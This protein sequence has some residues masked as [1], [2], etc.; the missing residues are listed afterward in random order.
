MVSRSGANTITEILTLG[1]L[2]ILIPIPWT[3][4]NEQGKNA[5]MVRET[6]LAIVLEEKVL[7][8]ATLL[9]AIDEQIEVLYKDTHQMVSI[10]LMYKRR[11]LML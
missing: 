9:Q 4:H 3:S 11:P 10:Y 2:C 6:G 5:E 7:S 8:G 1:K